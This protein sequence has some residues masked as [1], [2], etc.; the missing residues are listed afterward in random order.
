M[1]QNAFQMFCNDFEMVL[2]GFLVPLKCVVNVQKCVGN[3][4]LNAFLTFENA[5]KRKNGLMVVSVKGPNRK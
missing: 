1:F 4:F 5:L 2:N 3:A